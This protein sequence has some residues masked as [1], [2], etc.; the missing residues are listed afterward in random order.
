[1]SSAS[2]QPAQA[3]TQTQVTGDHL[4][5]TWAGPGRWHGAQRGPRGALTRL[6]DGRA[7]GPGGC[8]HF[9]PGARSTG[10]LGRP[11]APRLLQV[12]PRACTPTHTRH[13]RARTHTH[14][15]THSHKARLPQDSAIPARRLAAEGTRR[16]LA[17]RSEG[18]VPSRHPAP[19]PSLYLRPPP[20]RVRL[21]PP[22]GW[23][24][25]AR[26]IPA[27]PAPRPAEPGPPPAPRPSPGAGP[28]PAP[29][30]PGSRAR[31]R[32]AG[33]GSAAPGPRPPEIPAGSAGGQ[34]RRGSGSV[35]RRSAPTAP[36]LARWQGGGGGG[37]RGRAAGAGRTPAPFFLRL[38]SFLQAPR[39]TSQQLPHPP[40]S[41]PLAHSLT[42]RDAP[43]AP[44]LCA[45]P[46][47][48][49]CRTP[50]PACKA[51]AE[52]SPSL[53]FIIFPPPPTRI[54]PTRGWRPTA[55]SSGSPSPP[56]PALTSATDNL[57][58]SGGLPYTLH[59]HFVAL[60]SPLEK[61]WKTSQG[62]QNPRC[63]ASPVVPFPNF[64]GGTDFLPAQPS[65]RGCKER[66]VNFAA[67][68]VHTFPFLSFRL[69]G[70]ADQSKCDCA[71]LVLHIHDY[72]FLFR[73]PS[74]TLQVQSI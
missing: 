5:V 17:P 21:P 31:G 73:F 70:S 63:L 3:P 57:R 30:P 16:K 58:D 15:H 45:P 53:P 72:K 51:G 34:G 38:L 28:P 43:R 68:K 49:S 44:T 13:R 37:R 7:G 47:P 11:G 66:R 20:P 46:P 12:G 6:G 19:R 23:L 22:P 60:L 26:S 62:P 39:S 25:A 29:T 55:S 1:M 50:R 64:P 69:P 65:S 59:F 14:T 18:T 24:Q 71:P 33:E 8:G 52:G 54:G 61:L 67:G 74:V 36:A 32:E 9:P 2:R 10:W 56:A 40:D 4:R 48:S 41:L 35:S 42:W 27:A